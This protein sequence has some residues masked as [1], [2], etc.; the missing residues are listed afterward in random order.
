MVFARIRSFDNG[1]P[2]LYGQTT[3]RSPFGVVIKA[4]DLQP[5]Y[6]GWKLVEGGVFIVGIG[7]NTRVLPRTTVKGTYNSN[8]E[9]TSTSSPT[10]TL[11]NPSYSFKVGDVIY[12]V[13]CYAEVHFAAGT[14][15]ENDT[16]TLEINNVK[17]SVTAGANDDTPEEIAAL[18]ASGSTYDAMVANGLRVTRTGALLQIYAPDAY[19]IKAYSSN[20]TVTINVRTTEPGYFGDRNE[21][22]GTILAIAPPTSRS[23]ERVIT[24]AANAAYVIPANSR[25]GVQ[26]DEFGWLGIYDEPCDFSDEPVRHLAPIAEA[27]GVY[28]QNLPYC[29]MQLKRKFND[30]RIF[31]RFYRNV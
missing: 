13:A 15:A 19:S 3:R 24:L 11:N 10:L 22:I 26:V 14:Y 6:E 27:D 20:K 16:V 7:N 31:K 4:E 12:S 28:E 8:T 1:K 18:Y 30:L 25:V 29:D 2:I 23:G 5:N 17:Y 21:P 9:G